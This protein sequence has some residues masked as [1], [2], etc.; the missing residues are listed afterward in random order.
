MRVRVTTLIASTLLLAGCG[1]GITVRTATAPD[2]N[3]AGR[4]TFRFL[5]VPGRRDGG[6][7][8]PNDPMLANSITNRALREDIRRALIARGYRPAE[9]G[10]ADFEVAMYAAAHQALDIATYN[11]GY[12]WRGWPQEYTEVTPYTRGTVII[13]IVDP[14]SQ[15]LLWRGQGVSSVPDDPDAYMHNLNKVVKAVVKK[16]PMAGM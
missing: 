15:Q 11:Y 16:L 7:S 8:G 14:R 9:G 6:Q 10:P 4:S 5:P 2:F 13:D 12:T 1:N 3:I